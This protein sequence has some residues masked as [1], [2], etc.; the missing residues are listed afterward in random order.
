[1]YQSCPSVCLPVCPLPSFL[2]I[3]LGT[4]AL[5]RTENEITIVTARTAL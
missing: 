3:V 1:M 5:T 4:W 2:R